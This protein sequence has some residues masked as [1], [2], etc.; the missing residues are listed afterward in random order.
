[1]NPKRRSGEKA[2]SRT[3]GRSI[4]TMH[5]AV[6]LAHPRTTDR[7]VA[8]RTGWGAIFS[9]DT[10]AFRAAFLQRRETDRTPELPS[11]CG[12]QLKTGG[13]EVFDLQLSRDF[14]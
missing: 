7:T 11:L 12:Q 6:V 14:F 13:S 3:L 1:M 8:L 4:R 5:D 10:D 9:D 2:A